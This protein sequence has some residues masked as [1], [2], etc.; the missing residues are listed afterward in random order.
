MRQVNWHDETTFDVDGRMFGCFSDLK[1][2]GERWQK[3]SH[4]VAKSRE[5]LDVTIDALQLLK[6]QSIIELGV[7]QGEGFGVAV[8]PLGRQH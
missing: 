5:T 1:E 4:F 6:P 2:M 8:L 3:D 7:F